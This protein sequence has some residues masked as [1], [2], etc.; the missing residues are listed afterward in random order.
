M[1]E[2][3]VRVRIAYDVSLGMK[4]LHEGAARPVIHRDLNRYFT[5]R[6]LGCDEIALFDGNLFSHN[7]LIHLNGRAVVADFGESR[8]AGAPEENNNMTKQP[9]VIRNNYKTNII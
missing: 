2:C 8:F 1:L 3:G 4:Y 9:G 7:I 6:L 5:P